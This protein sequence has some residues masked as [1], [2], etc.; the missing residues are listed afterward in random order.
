MN[1][2][3]CNVCGDH[4]LEEVYQ[5]TADKSLSSLSE[6]GMS[7]TSVSFCHSCEHLQTRQFVNESDYYDNN[8][9]IL[10]DSD[11]EDQ[12]YVITDGKAVY[13]TEHQI[14][15]LLSKVDIFN[16]IKILDY[17]CAKSSAMK[18]LLQKVGAANVYL[19]DVSSNYLPFWKKFLNESNW[20]VYET[21]K[22][23]TGKFDLVTSFFSLEH[24]SNLAEI[25]SKI[26][27][28]LKRGGVFY[29]VVPNFLTNIADMIVIDHPNHFTQSSMAY[30]LRENGFRLESVDTESHRGALVVKAILDPDFRYSF[31]KNEYYSQVK[32]LAKFWI[33]SSQKIS[34]FEKAH[35]GKVAAIYGAGFYGAFLAKNIKDLSSIKYVIDQNTF[36]HG[37]SFLDHKIISLDN[38]PSDVEVVYVGLN[39]TFSRKI[40]DEAFSSHL[41]KPSFFYL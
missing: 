24:I 7:Q 39:P 3:V 6:D 38:L 32:E 11:D 9:N 12:I 26:R 16:G 13:R 40:I 22:E 23:W 4:F 41:S 19:Y 34:D 28:L 5:A 27:T 2:Q 20:S 1:K 29:A 21:P 25:M 31:S 17:G 15:T 35:K 30:M 8:Y 36:L 14:E 10:S 33:E 18:M 37:R